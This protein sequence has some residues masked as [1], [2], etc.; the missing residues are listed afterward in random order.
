MR[1]HTICSNELLL[2][3]ELDYL[4]KV[5]HDINGYPHKV[6]DSVFNSITT[7]HQRNAE[8]SQIN[9]NDITRIP[10]TLPY[11][12]KEGNTVTKR[13]KRQLKEL[14]PNTININVINN[15]KRISSCFNNKDTIL[16]EHKHDTVYKFKCL[17]NGCD[18]TYI[19]ESGRRLGERIADHNGRDNKSH[20]IKHSIEQN[21]PIKT[22]DQFEII[23][24]G[25]RLNYKKRKIAEALAIRHDKPNL[26]IQELS[27][28]LIL[29]N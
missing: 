4:R 15:A 25:F 13:L 22:N 2:K 3:K 6:I 24:S 20:I 23:N 14:I 18:A 26:N 16:K 27:T 8:T 21:H 1:A 28:P 9:N 29:F 10:I 11:A 7:I 12:G 5:F 19:G 17:E